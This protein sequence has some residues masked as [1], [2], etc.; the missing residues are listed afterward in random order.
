MA[1]LLREYAII[2]SHP[3]L[4]QAGSCLKAHCVCVWGGGGGGG[5]GEGGGGIVTDDRRLRSPEGSG[6][7]AVGH[8]RRDDAPLTRARNACRRIR[9]SRLV[10]GAT[11]HACDVRTAIIGGGAWN[12]ARTQKQNGV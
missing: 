2:D 12:Y 10:K 4:A 3:S 9:V 5:G 11:R 8:L 1:V 6:E 7:L